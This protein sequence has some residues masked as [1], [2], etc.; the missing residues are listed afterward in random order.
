VRDLGR[1]ATALYSGVVVTQDS[2]RQMLTFDPRS[3]YG[4]GTRTARFE[5]SDAVGHTGSL[6]GFTSA[7]W[8]FPTEQMAVV[9]STNL[10]RINPNAIVASL[11]RTAFRR[12]GHP[13]VPTPSPS[14]GASPG[15]SPAEPSAPP[16]AP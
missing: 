10:G 9:V 11:V 7:M 6:R 2:L 13:I 8:Y 5:L 12:L 15:A 3:A 14:P 1:W 4:L 16:E